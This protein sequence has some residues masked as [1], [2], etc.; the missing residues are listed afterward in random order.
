MNLLVG[1]ELSL[2]WLIIFKGNYQ[3]FSQSR[4]EPLLAELIMKEWNKVKEWELHF[5]GLLV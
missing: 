4:T 3:G 1:Q 5:V 2:K